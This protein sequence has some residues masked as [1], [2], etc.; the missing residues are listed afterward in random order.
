MEGVVAKLEAEGKPPGE[1]NLRLIHGACRAMGDDAC[2]TEQFEKLVK[3]YPKP[4]YW[5]NLVNV[6]F[7]DKKSTDKQQLNVMRLATH[8]GAVSEPL[9]FEECAQIAMDL[10]LPGEAQALLEEAFN[11]KY[12]VEPQHDRAR[13]EASGRSQDAGQR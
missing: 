12:I 13:Q 11:K 7:N 4:E 8:V 5:Q 1:Q 9:K 6:L 10:G 3:H 2:E